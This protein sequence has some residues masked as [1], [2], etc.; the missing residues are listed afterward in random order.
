MSRVN[1][2]IHGRH[3]G[4]VSEFTM[5]HRHLKLYVLIQ[6]VRLIWISS[7]QSRFRFHHKTFETKSGFEGLLVTQQMHRFAFGTRKQK[8]HT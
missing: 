6:E 8:P 4:P 3:N 1:K 2:L 7:L 5:I